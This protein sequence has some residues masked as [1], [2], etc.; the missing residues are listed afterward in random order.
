MAQKIVGCNFGKIIKKNIQIFFYVLNFKKGIEKS[1]DG[2]F[3]ECLSKYNET[4]CSN[5]S[6]PEVNF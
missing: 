5:N 2:N 4:F 6:F 1:R 3:I